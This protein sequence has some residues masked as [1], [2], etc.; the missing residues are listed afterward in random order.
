MPNIE[1]LNNTNYQLWRVQTRALLLE[2][3]YYGYAVGN[4]TRDSD[5]YLSNTSMAAGIVMSQMSPAMLWRYRDDKY[6]EAHVLWKQIADDHYELTRRTSE[7]LSELLDNIKLND[8]ASFDDYV[9]AVE[10][11]FEDLKPRHKDLNKIQYLRK[12]LPQE[13]LKYIDDLADKPDMAGRAVTADNFIK[14]LRAHELN[15]NTNRSSYSGASSGVMTGKGRGRGT[16][17]KADGHNKGE[18]ST[19]GDVHNKADRYVRGG[20]YFLRGRGSIRGR[21]GVVRQSIS[22]EGAEKVPSKLQNVSGEGTEK[23]SSTLQHVSTEI[24]DSLL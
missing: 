22:G 2:K 18:E 4:I 12:G 24:R 16:F 10:V 5:S 21:G 20:G 19:K 13:W 23:V 9:Q 8:Y 3:G 11:L 7:K 15:K 6:I 17:L 1:P 14:E